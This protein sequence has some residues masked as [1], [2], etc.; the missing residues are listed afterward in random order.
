MK[1]MKRRPPVHSARFVLGA[2]MVVLLSAVASLVP[3]TSAQGR[4]RTIPMRALTTGA[5]IPDPYWSPSTWPGALDK[6]DAAAGRRPQVV[7]WYVQWEGRQPF[8]TASAS[9][10]RT[11]GQ[12]PMITWESWD[13]TGT[14][15]Q[16][17]YSDA[18]ILAGDYDAYI[19][20]WAKAAKAYGTTVYVRWGAEMNGNWNPWDPGV[21]GNTAAQY[22]AAWRHIHA[23]FTA[24]G[25]TNVKWAW[26]PITEYGGSTPLASVYPGDAYVDLVG[27]DGYN[28]GTTRP[29]SSWQ[30]FSQVFDATVT[31]IRTL[32]KKP[33]WIFEM[34]S[35]EQGGNK[36]AWIT[37]MFSALQRDTRISGFVWFNAN[38]ETDWRI[39]S[40]PTAQRAFA[41]GMAALPRP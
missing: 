33:L 11:R 22:V 31:K 19:T 2:I 39:E 8:P 4:P 28:W 12:T 37:D 1:T 25:A 23:I 20:Q 32:T 34:A 5:Y 21:N 3:A 29:W 24:Q 14:A 38:K 17:V 16:P 15:D 6:F 26:T 10:V 13:W 40:S 30:S 35:A 9:Y 36:A 7:Q 18:R 41:A 27:V